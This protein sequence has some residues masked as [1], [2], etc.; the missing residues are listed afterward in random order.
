[1]NSCRE[2]IRS[3]PVRCGSARTS[4]PCLDKHALLVSTQGAVIYSVGAYENHYFRP[5]VQ[6]KADLS[7]S[8]YAAR[9]I[10]LVHASAYCAVGALRRRNDSGEQWV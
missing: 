9:S 7:D 5:E 1:M 6:G 10:C 3:A 4:S 8:Y 2:K